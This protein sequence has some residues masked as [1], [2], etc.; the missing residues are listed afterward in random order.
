MQSILIKIEHL[1]CSVLKKEKF[2]S[3]YNV[4]NINPPLTILVVDDG[5]FNSSPKSSF[6]FSNEISP[7]NAILVL[8]IPLKNK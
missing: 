8:L 7:N 6:Y 1:K 3:C 5:L 4:N 2:V